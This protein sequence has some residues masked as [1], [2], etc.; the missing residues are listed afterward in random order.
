MAFDEIVVRL[1]YDHL[2]STIYYE[3]LE[4]VDFG[5]SGLN[6]IVIGRGDKPIFGLQ[7]KLVG[8]MRG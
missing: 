3:N 8:H 2:L 4:A 6:R 5:I 7:Q 1:A